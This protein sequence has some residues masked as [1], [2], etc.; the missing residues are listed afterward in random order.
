MS[1]QTKLNDY[2]FTSEPESETRKNYRNDRDWLEPLLPF[3]ELKSDERIVK[4]RTV[5]EM[6][7]KCCP[8]TDQKV[9]VGKW[10][11]AFENHL[12]SKVSFV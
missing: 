3:F 1:V 10:K 6:V 8:E 2:Q 4:G 11:D 9:I 5:F 7:C 12:K